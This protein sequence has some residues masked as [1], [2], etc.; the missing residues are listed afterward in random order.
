MLRRYADALEE[1]RV[2]GDELLA[3]DLHTV[4]LGGSNPGHPFAQLLD[5]PPYRTGEATRV[6][7]LV[8]QLE[9]Q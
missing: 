5:D 9:A 7:N 8:E 4:R 2:I 1:A 3:F 6:R